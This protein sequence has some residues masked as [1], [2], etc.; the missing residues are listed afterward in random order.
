MLALRK[1]PARAVVLLAFPVLF[2]AGAATIRTAE[3][4]GFRMVP[5][6]SV[7]GFPE[8]DLPDWIVMLESPLVYYTNVSPGVARVIASEYTEAHRV[9]GVPVDGPG[10]YDQHDAF[11]AP[12]SGFRGIARPGPTVTIFRRLPGPGSSGKT[13]QPSPELNGS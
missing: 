12:L 8:G 13:P 5:F 7:S 4:D 11:F 1:Q 3:V 6:D 2:Y 10:W 9:E